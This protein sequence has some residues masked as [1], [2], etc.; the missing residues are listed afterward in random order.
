MGFDQ[1]NE[2]FG[3]DQKALMMHRKVVFVSKTAEFDYVI[4]ARKVASAEAT[5]LASVTVIL[6]GLRMGL[7]AKTD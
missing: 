5:E 7:V 6:A 3:A 1:L 2:E 4:A